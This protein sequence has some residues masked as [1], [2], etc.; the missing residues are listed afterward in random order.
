M[1]IISRKNKKSKRLGSLLKIE[2]EPINII[3]FLPNRITFDLSFYFHTNKLLPQVKKCEIIICHEKRVKK[4]NFFEGKTDTR[5]ISAVVKNKSR[6]K[7][8]LSGVK[9]EILYRGDVAL[10]SFVSNSRNFKPQSS[11][12]NNAKTSTISSVSRPKGNKKYVTLIKDNRKLNSS[13]SF[14]QNL[15][16]SNHISTTALQKPQLNYKT[17]AIESVFKN[18]IDPASI[19]TAP[20]S[21]SQRSIKNPGTIQKRGNSSKELS[22]I[23]NNHLTRQLVINEKNIGKRNQGLILKKVLVE[24]TY[25]KHTER[26]TISKVRRLL[27]KPVRIKIKIHTTE[28]KVLTT[29]KIV[30]MKEV[31]DSI[32]NIDT[33]PSISACKDGDGRISISVQA[34]DPA[35]AKV[36]CFIKNF[37]PGSEF[38]SYAQIADLDVTSITSKTFKIKA[39][40]DYTNIIRMIYLTKD[41]KVNY[42]FV[43]TSVPGKLKDYEANLSL[44]AYNIGNSISVTA[45]NIPRTARNLKI[46]RK[47]RTERTQEEILVYNKNLKQLSSISFFDSFSLK[48]YHEYEY[49][50]EVIDMTGN[51]FNVNTVA[52]E[53]FVKKSRIDSLKSFT[54][55]DL[56]ISRDNNQFSRSFNVSIVLNNQTIDGTDKLLRKSNLS[57]ER[58]MSPAGAA[59]PVLPEEVVSEAFP[60]LESMVF[61]YSVIRINKSLGTKEHL[62]IFEDGLFVDSPDSILGASPY[63]PAFEYEYCFHLLSRTAISI[64]NKRVRALDPK[65]KKSY[66]KNPSIFDSLRTK[67]LSTT[68]SVQTFGRAASSPI[69]NRSRMH[70]SETGF[71]SVVTVVKEKIQKPVLSMKGFSKKEKTFLSFMFK[72]GDVSNVD[73]ILV[74]LDKDGVESPIA[75]L[76]IP[77]DRSQVSFIDY[78]SSDDIGIKH[79]RAKLI[80]ND[81]TSSPMA[82]RLT[83]GI[84]SHQ[85]PFSY[86]V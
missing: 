15:K 79:Y 29:Q 63:N 50:A 44:C 31:V 18:G 47:D 26:I 69:F 52:F 61:S 49:R 24:E 2:E 3:K 6:S 57:L 42:N 66:Y 68:Q 37:S 30:N 76:M 56:G 33:L 72:E 48:N 19:A 45:T 70:N 34:K 51:L 25:T 64:L 77:P 75:A 23:N 54:T 14:K 17:A 55:E 58:I 28:G 10:N 11:K 39:N 78:K 5:D 21:V 46:F 38:T 73:H 74:F 40:T 8:N 59:N 83:L 32:K 4:Q 27:A 22:K 36:T 20:V 9:K 12:L 82:K 41:G 84:G 1:A 80:Y 7:A 67:A 16:S 53:K 60:D 13:T 85:P 71:I 81:F 43:S 65:L 86:K 35:I 62:G